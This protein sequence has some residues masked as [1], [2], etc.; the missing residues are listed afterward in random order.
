M[1]PS[2]IKPYL[3]GG[4]ALVLAFSHTYVYFFGKNEGLKR[5]YE[6]K[7]DV[8]EQQEQIRLDNERK[9]KEARDAAQLANDGWQA[10]ADYWKRNPV[11][12]VLPGRCDSTA[13]L[14]ATGTVE[15]LDANAGT[16]LPDPTGNATVE[17]SV[18]RCEELIGKGV[19][20]AAHVLHLQ[21][22]VN[23]LCEAYGCE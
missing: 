16:R 4:I 14:K 2:A 15:G 13:S 11:V 23:G 8:E 17:V 21:Q 6:F 7:A 1:I 12:R 22:Y 18:D 9:L 5:Y 20:D 19:K 10:A 3:Y